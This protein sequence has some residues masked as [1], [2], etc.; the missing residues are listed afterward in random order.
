[1]PRI[2]APCL[3]VAVEWQLLT[4]AD[5]VF[6]SSPLTFYLSFFLSVCLSFTSLF[7][8]LCFPSSFSL[9][10]FLHLPRSTPLS[11]S[12]PPH[13][14]APPSIRL[15]SPCPR[16]PPSYLPHI[17]S[18]RYRVYFVIATQVTYSLQSPITPSLSLS[19][20]PQELIHNVKMLLFE[21]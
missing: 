20:V 9:D 1:M 17:L 5:S 4:H 10:F 14:F 21:N 2:L 3:L 8:C 6:L 18:V 11:P 16:P 15:I 19:D 13:L 7:L 12:L